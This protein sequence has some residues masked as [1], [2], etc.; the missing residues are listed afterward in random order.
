MKKSI[1]HL[2][3]II[4][5]SVLSSVFASSCPASP[6]FSLPDGLSSVRWLNI[7]WVFPP[8]E[9]FSDWSSVLHR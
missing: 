8:T 3:L 5:L 7:S 1:N 4:L 6:V 2:Y 9:N